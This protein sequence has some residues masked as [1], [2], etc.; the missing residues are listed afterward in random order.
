MV[1]WRGS[2]EPN[3]VI[4]QSVCNIDIVPAL[5]AISGFSNSLA[6]LP[7]DG[8][9]I[10]PVLF[11]KNTVERDIFWRYK[12]ETAFRRGDWKLRNDDEL[13][14]LS[15]DISEK[16]NVANAHPDK[17]KELRKAFKTVRL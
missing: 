15:T 3:Q 14:D 9:D 11:D 8:V 1:C 16:N 12:D 13:Y 10:S 17:L 2:V 5:R 4:D 7:I 6:K